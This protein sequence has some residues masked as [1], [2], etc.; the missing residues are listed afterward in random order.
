MSLSPRERTGIVAVIAII[1]VIT[2]FGWWVRG[3]GGNISNAQYETAVD[4]LTVT[5]GRETET[6]DSVNGSS[7]G[8]KRGKRGG[9]KSTRSKNGKKSKSTKSKSSKS[10]RAA[11]PKIRDIEKEEIETE[12]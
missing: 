1:V 2:A 8:D 10:K 5:V 12:Y 6:T 3:N 7:N 4:S 11:T 9:K